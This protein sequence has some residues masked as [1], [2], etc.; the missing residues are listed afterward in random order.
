MIRI[1]KSNYR[2]AT[3]ADVSTEFLEMPIA[4]KLLKAESLKNLK[5][6]KNTLR[7]IFNSKV[8]G[9][10]GDGFVRNVKTVIFRYNII[11]FKR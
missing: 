8:I 7:I 2:Y 11:T 10:D 4:N 6:P 3:R 1:K 5:V 9:Y